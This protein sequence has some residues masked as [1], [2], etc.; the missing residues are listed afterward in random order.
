MVAAPAG[1]ET[2]GEPEPELVV[3]PLVI[4]TAVVQQAT[5]YQHPHGP[6]QYLIVATAALVVHTAVV[7]RVFRLANIFS[8]ANIPM[9]LNSSCV[10]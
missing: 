8:I 2:A 5:A 3:A 7:E 6:E 10:Q 9:G 4:C 1:T